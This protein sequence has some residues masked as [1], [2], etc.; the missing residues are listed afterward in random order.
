M[1]ALVAGFQVHV[2]KPV[3]PQELLD[4]IGRLLRTPVPA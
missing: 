4:L 2:A 1:E 3:L